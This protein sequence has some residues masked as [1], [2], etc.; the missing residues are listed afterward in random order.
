MTNVADEAKQNK[1]FRFL[2]GVSE[3]ALKGS[4]DIEQ[5]IRVVQ[6]LL[7]KKA[8]ATNLAEYIAQGCPVVDYVQTMPRAKIRRQ[9][10]PEL[11]VDLDT[12]PFIPEGWA[13]K[14]GDHQKGGQFSWDSAAV[15]LWLSPNQQNSK[16]IEGNKLR[17]ELANQPVLNA[18]VLDFL[19][20]NP[21]I[22][23]YEW[24]GKAVFFW[25]T[26]YRSPS[27]SSCVRYLYWIGGRW[28]WHASWLGHDWIGDDPALVSR[29]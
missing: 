11:V 16:H 22:I 7:D 15:E 1:F 8:R 27:G 12:D 28:S 17:K 19:L 4:L 25:G 10:P 26:I 6:V 5:F 20:A 9:K 24:K 21:D 13:V 3:R 23:P 29:K 18:N 14:G 2:H